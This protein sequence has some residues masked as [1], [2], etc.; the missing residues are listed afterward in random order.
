MMRVFTAKACGKA[1]LAYWASG[2]ARSRIPLDARGK[3]LQAVVANAKVNDRPI[4]VQLDSGSPVSYLSGHA[5]ARAG[6]QVNAEGVT[7]GGITYGVYG[8]GME[9][10]L[11]PFQSFKIG[12]EEIKNTRLRVANIELGN[13]AD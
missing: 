7:S 9:T 2:L 10:F 5:A 12:D 4:R 11:A 3:Y 13:E 8:K 1:N 6:I